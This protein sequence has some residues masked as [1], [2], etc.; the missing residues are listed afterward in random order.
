MSGGGEKGDLVLDEQ[1]NKVEASIRDDTVG[2]GRSYRLTASR[3]FFPPAFLLHPSKIYLANDR[4]IF[5]STFLYINSNK[6]RRNDSRCL[7][8]RSTKFRVQGIFT[9]IIFDR[10]QH[11]VY[12]ARVPRVVES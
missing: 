2:Y 9:R 7:Y 1:L 3:T 5:H 10:P 4:V 11:F 12:F 8:R 6:I